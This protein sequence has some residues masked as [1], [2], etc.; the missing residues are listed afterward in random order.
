[1]ITKL[2]FP[3]QLLIVFLGYLLAGRLA[4][5]LAIPPGYATAIWPAAGIALAACVLLG[6]RVWPA[7]VL[8]SVCVNLENSLNWDQGIPALFS[9]LLV[10]AAIGLGAAAQ[11]CFGAFL[12]RYFLGQHFNLSDLTAVLK[13]VLIVCAGSCLVNSLVGVT[14]LWLA[15]V[16]E[17]DNL[18]YNWFTWWVGDAL[19]VLVFSSLI[20]VFYARP[21]AIWASR[22]QVMLLALGVSSVVMLALYITASRWELDRQQ[23]EFDRQSNRLFFVVE[24][25]IERYFEGLYLLQSGIAS[26]LPADSTDYRLRVEAM[27]ERNPGLQGIAWN[28][29]LRAEEQQRFEKQISADYGLPIELTQ[30]DS[31]GVLGAVSGVGDYIVIRHIAPLA[32]NQAAL[33]FDISS[34]P[35]AREALARARSSGRPAATDPVTLV[36]ETEAQAGV[37]VYFPVFYGR[38]GDSG[39]AKLGFLSGVFRVGALFETLF[40]SE[41]LDGFQLSV[42]AATARGGE[43]IYSNRPNGAGLNSKQDFF[44]KSQRLDFADRQWQLDIRGD[45][46]FLAGSRSLM[47]WAVLAGGMLFT[48]LLGMSLLVL[49]AQRFQAETARG[50]LQQTVEALYS[51]QTQ[52]VE[53]EKMA[54]LGDMVAGLA[55]E[56]NTP[57]GVAVTAVSTLSNTIERLQQDGPTDQAELNQQL[58]RLGEAGGIVASNVHKA[59]ALVSSFKQVSI[60]QSAGEMREVNLNEHLADLFVYLQAKCK[61]QGHRLELDCPREISLLTVPGGIVQVVY[62]LVQNSLDHA[63]GDGRLGR[64]SLQV[65]QQPS[66]VV[67]DYRDNG[68]GIEAS[69]LPK[70]FEPFFKAQRGDGGAGLGLHLVNTIV[71]QQLRG[72]IK[73]ESEV[74]RGVH[75]TI[76]LP[77]DLAPSH[78]GD[79]RRDYSLV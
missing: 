53:A 30:L 15:G 20:F 32:S 61:R 24:S 51:T 67:L 6:Y 13:F 73:L 75:F 19:G 71:H 4:L 14:T 39:E 8:G 5:L 55:H 21:R 77:T 56:L 57:L 48:G 72:S 16:V 38:G 25:A 11:A 10:P 47:P 41:V 35:K 37:V 33:G 1:M 23:A 9:S 52:L 17:A 76:I 74:G 62:S 69:L 60:D 58:V 26:H 28:T 27:L 79:T 59:A 2:S 31:Q 12:L 50:E 65:S 63:F 34:N 44:S 46:H 54:A 70:V 43:E 64:M 78:D 36:Q 7:I 49:T 3:K 68:V 66:R 42:G 18:L 29:P 45:Q 22:K 40:S